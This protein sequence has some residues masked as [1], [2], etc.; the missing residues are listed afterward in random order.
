ML[1]A[2]PSA[3][4]KPALGAECLCPQGERTTLAGTRDFLR[5]IAD[6][7]DVRF[8]CHRCKSRFVWFEGE[9]P[10]FAKESEVGP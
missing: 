7:L 3:K 1:H 6:R 8:R 4:G 10:R 5:R 9:A 2:H